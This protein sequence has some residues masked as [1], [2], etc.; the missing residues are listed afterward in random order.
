[1]KR[2]A[3]LIGCVL[4]LVPAVRAAD[5]IEAAM[6]TN[7]VETLNAFEPVREVLQTSSAVIMNG[8]DQLVY[9]TVISADGLIATKASEIDGKDGLSVR[10]GEE[11][12]T[13]V[14]VVGVDPAWDVALVKVV[15]DG[16]VP[17][18]FAKSSNVAQGTW[19]V[20]NG[21]T[22][23]SRRR[24]M[25]GIISANSREITG[26]PAVV[27]GVTLGTEKND[28]RV[29]EVA[30][31]GGAAKAGLKKGDVLVTFAGVK[32][33]SR[34]QLLGL[35]KSH[36]P[37][38]SVPITYKRG[39]KVN[40]AEIVLAAREDVMAEPVSRNDQMS[41]R[42]SHRRSSF[43]RV[44]QHDIPLNFESV[45]G[46]LLNLDGECLGINIARANRVETFTI[47]LEEL[48]EITSRLSQ[49]TPK[50]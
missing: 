1:M 22:S 32:L 25:V 5:N 24:P 37:G 44:L 47:P 27:L 43:K 42:F 12:Y 34:E 19:V 18:R 4:A 45:G 40:K 6:R 23:R 31:E 8:R 50:P 33:E 2:P 41:G 30:K 39:E 28:L 46:P 7:G 14:K 15:A 35:L 29:E 17:V 26:G 21:A 16:L 48:Q 49:G 36:S 9:G 3:I 10:V 13:D 11:V 20:A 38:E